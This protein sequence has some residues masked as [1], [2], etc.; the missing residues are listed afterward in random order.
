MVG[1][2]VAYGT[3]RLLALS[4]GVF[5]IAMTLLVIELKV[6]DLHGDEVSRLATEL[7]HE[8]GAYLAYALSFVIIGRLWLGHHRLFRRVTAT[9]DRLLRINLVLLLFVA[10]LPFPTA[11]LSRYGNLT[12]GVVP[13]AACMVVLDLLLAMM[14]W[15]ALW[16]GLF[17][18]EVERREV[19]ATVARNL[20]M[21]AVFLAS[22]PVAFVQPDTALP[23]W[24][25]LVVVPRLS[26]LLLARPPRRG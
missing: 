4:D 25:L 5:A 7:R 26:A 16:R 10:V 2:A 14:W 24:S 23:M 8:A 12:W 18:D 9:D 22:I 13:Y 15:W 19:R 1:R 6:P 21:A 17:A 11:V 3:E 20:G